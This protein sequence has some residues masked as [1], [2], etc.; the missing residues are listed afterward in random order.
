MELKIVAT[1]ARLLQPRVQ[2]VYLPLRFLKALM[3]SKLPSGRIVGPYAEDLIGVFT[4]ALVSAALRR[5]AAVLKADKPPQ[6]VQWP[7]S[8]SFLSKNI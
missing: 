4:T 7:K 5:S 8:Q 6:W 3:W 1:K 2:F